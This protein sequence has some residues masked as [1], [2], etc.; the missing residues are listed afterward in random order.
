MRGSVARRF[1]AAPGPGHG[2]LELLELLGDALQRLAQ[3]VGVAV[4]AEHRPDRDD[5][6]L[7]EQ[8]AGEQRAGGAGGEHHGGGGVGAVAVQRRAAGRPP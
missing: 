1:D 2:L 4:E 3:H 5:P 8:D 6:P 7:L